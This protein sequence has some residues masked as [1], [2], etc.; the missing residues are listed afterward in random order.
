MSWIGLT[1]LFEKFYCSVL[2]NEFYYGIL[3]HAKE[4]ENLVRFHYDVLYKYLMDKSV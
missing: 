4:Y 3:V 2:V 1:N